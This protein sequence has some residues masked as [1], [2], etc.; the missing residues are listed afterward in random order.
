LTG[1]RTI[2]SKQ[3]TVTISPPSGI[4]ASGQNFDLALIIEGVDNVIAS[5]LTARLDNND[6][7][8]SIVPCIT[9]AP[10]S[11][12]VVVLQCPA[13]STLLGLTPGRHVFSINYPLG[14]DPAVSGALSA[15]VTWEIVS[16]Q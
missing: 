8:T 9:Q 2:L 10:P 1:T 7:T 11:S 6:V 4:Y 14:P 12:G 15:R 5:S 16:T 13:A 3:S